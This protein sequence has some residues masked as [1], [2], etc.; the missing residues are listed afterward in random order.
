MK[1]N[2]IISH[3]LLILSIFVMFTACSSLKGSKR[4]AELKTVEVNPMISEED[5]GIANYSPADE[6]IDSS[7]SRPFYRNDQL[8]NGYYLVENENSSWKDLS[9]KIYGNEDQ[10]QFLQDA[11]F[12]ANL[13]VG[14][15]IYY[16][17]NVRPNDENQLLLLEEDLQLQAQLN[18]Q[19]SVENLAQQNVEHYENVRTP[20][21]DFHSDS[22]TVKKGDS[23]WT[24]AEKHLQS[25]LNWKSIYD[26][27]QEL[28]KNPDMI[29][30]GLKIQLPNQLALKKK[31]QQDNFASE[32]KYLEEKA[33][34]K[35]AVNHEF[36]DKKPASVLPTPKK[37]E[38]PA[39]EAKSSPEQT[40]LQAAQVSPV[41]ES[42]NDQAVDKENRTPASETKE[43]A[44]N[45]EE[46]NVAA[47]VN[48]HKKEP[49]K[50]ALYFFLI[51]G[52]LSGA[53]IGLILI[54]PQNN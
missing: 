44:A 12:N 41:N 35:K 34:E 18:A 23:L 30:A 31:S 32:N 50:K 37:K 15:L 40:I 4:H 9:L 11:N 13:E 48:S 47:A 26:L 53:V 49:N 27:N 46:R 38:A 51:L 43:L 29:Q 45:Q 1:S 21:N 42:H 7:L 24:I 10:S 52:L 20:S 5:A 6:S 2:Q 54:K 3:S 16:H 33:Q 14:Q 39:S 8:L 28:I 19:K 22:Y 25:G 36:N 17:S